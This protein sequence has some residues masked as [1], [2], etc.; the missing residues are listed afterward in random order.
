MS[1]APLT[2]RRTSEWVKGRNKL[3]ISTT[4]N[5]P[6]IHPATWPMNSQREN[7]D[8]IRQE[9]FWPFT[10]DYSIGSAGSSVGS[11]VGSIWDRWFGDSEQPSPS[12]SG[13]DDQA[14][15]N[16]ATQTEY[17]SQAFLIAALAVG[18]FLLIRKYG[19]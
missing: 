18:S 2:Q 8:S 4:Y 1:V 15:D 19:K 9:A 5:Y 12:P 17:T 14:A 10:G 13:N 7:W 3:A 11:Y 6:R 16:P